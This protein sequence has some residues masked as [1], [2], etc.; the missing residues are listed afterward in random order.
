MF[1]PQSVVTGEFCHL[2]GRE[3]V[4]SKDG[5][6]WRHWPVAEVGLRAAEVIYVHLNSNEFTFSYGEVK[7]EKM[8]R[9]DFLLKVEK[10]AKCCTRSFS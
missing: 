2:T 10:R 3:E 7:K 1:S 6:R 9:V 5:I 8:H 4:R